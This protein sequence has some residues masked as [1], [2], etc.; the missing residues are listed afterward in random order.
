MSKRHIELQKSQY[1][2]YLK[3]IVGNSGWEIL[4]DVGSTYVH[5]YSLRSAHL[6]MHGITTVVSRG[7]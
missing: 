1:V 2:V 7:L 3:G 5:I 6:P 4:R